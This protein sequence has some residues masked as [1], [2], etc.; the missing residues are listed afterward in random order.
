MGIKI[1]TN[2]DIYIIDLYGDMDLADANLLKDLVMKMIEK[3]VERFIINAQNVNSIDSSGMGAFIFISSTLKKLGMALAI[4]N[5]KGPVKNVIEKTKLGSYL[6][7]YEELNEAI[8]A[9][10]KN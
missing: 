9:L 2:Q 7:I 10:S 1:R 5:V 6:P 8:E 4:A 3:K